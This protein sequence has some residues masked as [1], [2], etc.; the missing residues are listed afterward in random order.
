MFR[1]ITDLCGAKFLP[2]S[3]VNFAFLNEKNPFSGGKLSSIE[4]TKHLLIAQND[5]MR[6]KLTLKK[7]R[8]LDFYLKNKQK[9]CT[10]NLKN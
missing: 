7:I 2:V 6:E 5:I 8:K 4:A 3:Y 10:T 1:A 9:N